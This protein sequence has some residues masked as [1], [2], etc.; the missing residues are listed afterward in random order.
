[1]NVVLLQVGLTNHGSLHGSKLSAFWDASLGEHP[2]QEAI[3][4]ED[5]RQT[6]PGL[7][8]HRAVG[9]GVQGTVLHTRR[10]VGIIALLAP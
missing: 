2:S 10:G 3:G 5:Q 1:M 4:V 9:D 8:H 6:G 7:G